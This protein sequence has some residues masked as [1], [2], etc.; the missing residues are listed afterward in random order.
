[1]NRAKSESLFFKILGKVVP[2]CYACHWRAYGKKFACGKHSKWTSTCKKQKSAHVSFETFCEH[3]LIWGV[4]PN[5][6]YYSKNF[7]HILFASRATC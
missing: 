5:P 6:F 7:S 3:F 2:P 1:M 4:A